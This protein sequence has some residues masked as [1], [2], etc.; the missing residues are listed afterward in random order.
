MSL[1]GVDYSAQRQQADLLTLESVLPL[2]SATSSIKLDRYDESAYRQSVDPS[3]LNLEWN[4]PKAT[5]TA[6]V[7][8][9][10]QGYNEGQWRG[11]KMPELDKQATYGSWDGDRTNKV[12]AAIRGMMVG[13]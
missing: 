6:S 7:S 13:Y 3:K 9:M 2:V 11:G 8:L 12:N 10:N 5:A 4:G 1:S